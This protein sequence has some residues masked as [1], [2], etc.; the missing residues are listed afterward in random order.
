MEIVAET[1]AICQTG[2]GALLLEASPV[3]QAP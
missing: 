3:D 1:T 2:T